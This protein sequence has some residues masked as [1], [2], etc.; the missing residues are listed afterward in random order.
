M[1]KNL[2]INRVMQDY[3]PDLFYENFQYLRQYFPH[4]AEKLT[5][6]TTNNA[7][8]VVEGD[9]LSNIIVGGRAIYEESYQQALTIQ[10]TPERN[11]RV[12]FDICDFLRQDTPAYNSLTLLTHQI[13]ENFIAPAKVKPIY[14]NND[15]GVLVV[16]GL[17]LGGHI[18]QILNQYNHFYCAI[19][20]ESV[21][22]LYHALHLHSISAWQNALRERGGDLFIWMDSNSEHVAYRIYNNIAVN[23]HGYPDGSRIF[24]HY[25]AVYYTQIH[26]KL[27]T[28]LPNAFANNGFID[29]EILMLQNYYGNL[30]NQYAI[31]PPKTNNAIDVPVVVVANGPSLDKLRPFLL[32]MAE[33]AIVISCGTA[34]ESVLKLGIIPDFHAELENNQEIKT[35]HERPIVAENIHKITLLSP[36]SVNPAVPR[37]FQRA[38]MYFRDSLTPSILLN[39]QFIIDMTA[40][41]CANMACRLAVALG[42]RQVYLFGVDFGK[43]ENAPDHSTLSIYEDFTNAVA[44]NYK[45]LNRFADSVVMPANFGGSV[46]VHSLFYQA[47]FYL[48]VLMQNALGECQFINCSD[49]V[50]FANARPLIPEQLPELPVIDKNNIRAQIFS[51]ANDSAIYNQNAQQIYPQLARAFKICAGQLGQLMEWLNPAI[52]PRALYLQCRA[53]L[54]NAEYGPLQKPLHHAVGGSVYF[55]SF[56][57]AALYYR[58]SDDERPLLIQT[59]K[60]YLADIQHRLENFQYE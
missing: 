16:L 17:G 5:N 26:Q 34:L 8:L 11:Q 29:D 38:L 40:P 15:G 30:K 52:T 2:A 1:G 31:I 46:L 56:Q 44:Q 51:T 18:D 4:I 60:N 23:A 10:M 35:I 9:E 27:L 25:D 42:A 6:L 53:V 33:R 7:Q 36:F 3:N 43:R 28:I 19:I 50:A 22:V 12:N 48:S 14:D 32:Q 39:E 21:E 41:N 45:N 57:Y 37:Q 49:G 13:Y 24:V 55:A 20:E 47:Q 59:I 58:I 54:H